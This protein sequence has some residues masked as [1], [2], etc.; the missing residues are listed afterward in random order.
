MDEGHPALFTITLSGQV[1]ED[2]TVGYAAM[3]GTAVAADY[4]TDDVNG[5]VTI[6]RGGLRRAPSLC[7]Q[8]WT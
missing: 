6:A 7:G 3:P 2:V 8:R 5:T 1:S 4:E